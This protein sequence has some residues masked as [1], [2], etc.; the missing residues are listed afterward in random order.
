MAA[1][2][3]WHMIKLTRNG[4]SK[5]MLLDV[6]F[7]S[8]HFLFVVSMTLRSKKLRNVDYVLSPKPCGP[9][10]D[11]GTSNRRAIS[12]TNTNDEWRCQTRHEYADVFCR[13]A[14][15]GMLSSGL[16]ECRPWRE[17]GKENVSSLPNE[18]VTPTLWFSCQLMCQ[19][20]SQALLHIVFTDLSFV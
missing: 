11:P 10:P 14:V 1:I 5:D 12:Y 20:S 18:P 3:T 19:F 6:S 17:N 16:F 7:F 8:P 13:R 9:F 15:F 2:C 4:R